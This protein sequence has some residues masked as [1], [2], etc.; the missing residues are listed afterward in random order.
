MTPLLSGVSGYD[1][2]LIL[3]AVVVVIIEQTGSGQTTVRLNQ[4]VLHDVQQDVSALDQLVSNN[5][6]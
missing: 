5:T 4:V 2:L 1:F 6:Q 3:A